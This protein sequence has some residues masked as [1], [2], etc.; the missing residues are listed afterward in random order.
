MALP[1]AAGC[2]AP[3]PA[4][5]A[6]PPA[7]YLGVATRL[8]DGDLVDFE[9]AMRGAGGAEAVSRYAE[10]AAAQYTLIRGYGFARHV[11]TLT[12][13]EGG[14]WRADAVYTISAALPEGLRTIDAEVTVAQCAQ[15]GIPTV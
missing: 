3:A 7:E 4:A 10:C 2:D 6:A 15:A 9:V 11:R 8:L 13:E 1:A 5:H 12:E 14:I